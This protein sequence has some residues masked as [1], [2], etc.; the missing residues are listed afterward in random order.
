V[1]VISAA[2]LP[3][4]GGVQRWRRQ[5]MSETA[6]ELPLIHGDN[7]LA[8]PAAWCALLFFAAGAAGRVIRFHR[9]KG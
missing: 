8:V 6:A 2:G 3:G 7:P 4:S 9:E 5:A 1:Y